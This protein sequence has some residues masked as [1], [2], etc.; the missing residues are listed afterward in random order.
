MH[1]MQTKSYRVSCVFCLVCRL[2]VAWPFTLSVRCALYRCWSV[3]PKLMMAKH[4]SYDSIRRIW[5][6]LFGQTKW[7]WILQTNPHWRNDDTF[8]CV[9]VAYSTLVHTHSTIWL[10]LIWNSEVYMWN[11]KTH[12]KQIVDIFFS[13]RSVG[14]NNKKKNKT[15]NTYRNGR[16]L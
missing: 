6:T 9:R 11:C 7:F 13:I 5:L 15:P 8:V 12:S 16:V 14:R 10:I 3:P 4:F 1:E 2:D